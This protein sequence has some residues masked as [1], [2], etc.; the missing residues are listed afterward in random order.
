M[1]WVIIVMPGG[2]TYDM[3]SDV[4]DQPLKSPSIKSRLVKGG[5]KTIFAAAQVWFWLRK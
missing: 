5:L 1:N 2:D 3:F 4:L